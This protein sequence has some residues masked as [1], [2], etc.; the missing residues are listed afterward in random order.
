MIDEEATAY[1]EAGHVVVGAVRGRPPNS[2]TIIRDKN[3][4]GK[5]EFSDDCPSKFKNYLS[6]SREKR[7]YVETRILISIA[8][9]IAHD[10]RSPDRVHDS[11]DEYDERCAQMIIE[12]NAGWA[13]DNRDGYFQ[14]LQEIGRSLVRANWP[15]VESVARALIEHKTIGKAEIIKLQFNRIP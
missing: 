2:V 11:A 8:G 4:A 15:W 9:T 14:Q 3:S 5:N 7:K 6:D 10:L 13:G 1:H 12:Q